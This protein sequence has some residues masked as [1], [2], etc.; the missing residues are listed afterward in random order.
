MTLYSYFESMCKLVSL[1][2][3]SRNYHGINILDKRYTIDFTLDCFLNGN[4]PL[5]LRANLAKVLVTLHIDKEPLEILD[6]PIYARV[7][8]EIPLSRLS[9]PQSVV[10]L[11]SKLLKLKEFFITFF[12][13]INGIQRATAPEYN[14]LT[15]QVLN[16]LEKMIKLGFYSNE[17]ELIQICN[18]VI[19]LLDGSSDFSSKDEEDAFNAFQENL[20]QNTTKQKRLVEDTF[21]RD[22]KLRYRNDEN[23]ATIFSIKKKI[24][25]ILY[26]IV[27]I[28]N[29]I[30][31]SKFLL[32]FYN[33][34]SSL[35]MNPT[36]SAKE[37][38]FLKNILAGAGID[39][40][41]QEIKKEVDSKVIGWMKR[42]Y[43]NKS[44]DMK[45]KSE[46]DIICILLD[47]ILYQDSVL[48]NS[49]FTL[50]AKYF[51]QIKMI[52]QCVNDVQ[53]LQ[54]EEEVAILKKVNQELT[55]MKKNAEE[56]DMWMGKTKVEFLKNSRI[57]MQKLDLLIDLCV[58]NPK[59]VIE[60][61]D[62]KK[63][64]NTDDMVLEGDDEK[65]DDEFEFLN[66]SELLQE[67]D[68]E[69][70]KVNDEDEVADEKNQRLLKNRNAHMVPIIIIR[71][72]GLEQAEDKN[73]YLKVL[74]KCYI[75]LIKFVKNNKA[76]Q[77]VLVDYIIK[78]MDDLE[79]GVH[80][81]EL[82]C[83][84]FKN[85]DLLLTYNLAP[86]IKKAIKIIDVLPKE[87]MKKTIM[88][89]FLSYFQRVNGVS[90]KEN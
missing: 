54:D 12:G 6:V 4:V 26:Y 79:F 47:I 11:P 87:T 13:D 80:A 3:L 58:Y 40:K 2:C 89:S 65:G 88:L 35:M 75:F 45:V 1:M 16:M 59:R 23:N 74:E 63:K 18:P 14:T 51:S 30:R 17:Q 72:Q 8:Q 57:F 82:I 41:D 61:D 86:I 25:D 20:K 73:C 64:K 62:K 55:F 33:A 42:A 31:L 67:W 34:D 37:M 32:E 90:V 49:A 24:I 22:K 78:F 71:Q 21:K 7:W 10:P 83:E 50:L 68:N 84:I 5:L 38:I 48:V 77:L 85:S 15:L 29:D 70:P 9:V 43:G 28:Q 76:N 81:W 66:L 60:F 27:D 36:N 46:K 52:I 53:L 44:V 69:D 19:S 39:D 56:M